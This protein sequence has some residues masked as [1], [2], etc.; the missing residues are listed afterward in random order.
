MSQLPV[1][2]GRLDEGQGYMV[3]S[4]IE[5]EDASDVLPGYRRKY[6]GISECRPARS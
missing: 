5:G 4:Y 6:N 2:M 1:A 3:L